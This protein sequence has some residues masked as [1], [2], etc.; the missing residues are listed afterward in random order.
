MPFPYTGIR[1]LRL[2]RMLIRA[3]IKK[4]GAPFGT[5]GPEAPTE[6]SF[7]CVLIPE[8]SLVYAKV[9]RTFCPTPQLREPTVCV[10]NTVPARRRL[11]RLL[12]DACGR[13]AVLQEKLEVL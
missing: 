9:R 3:I 12:T 7:G 5:R 2:L 4:K 8:S 13:A 11:E 6:V 1:R 10:V